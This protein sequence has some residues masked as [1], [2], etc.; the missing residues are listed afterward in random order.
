MT[1]TINTLKNFQ[2]DNLDKY[3]FCLYFVFN[4]NL[5][6]FYI[7]KSNNKIIT[8]TLNTGQFPEPL[9]VVKMVRNF[10]KGNVSMASNHRPILLLSVFAKIFEKVISTRI[11]RF[12]ENN[13]ILNSQ[14]HGLGLG[15]STV[16]V[17]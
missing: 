11:T 9:K 15:C 3:T 17:I 8:I 5:D 7:F 10:K 4:R 6:F 1:F 13:K 16:F 12:L 2:K 14:Q